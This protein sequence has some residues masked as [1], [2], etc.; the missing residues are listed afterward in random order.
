MSELRIKCDLG[1]YDI[2][3]VQMQ[4]DFCVDL[5]RSNIALFG[6]SMSGKTNFIKLLIN[7]LHKKQNESTEQVFIL[8]FSG[9]LQEYRDMPL[10]SAYFDNSNEEYVKRVFKILENILKSNTKA[11]GS[12]SFSSGAAGIPHTT[13]II[14]NLNA[15]VDETRYTA[16]HEK[17]GRLCRDGRSRGI[18]I[19]FTASDTKG[20]S[21]YLL[22]FE[23][24]IALGLSPEK[25]GEIFG[26][27]VEAVGNI[28]GRGYTNVT[29]RPN[30]ITGTFNM[31]RPY[32]VQCLIAADIRDEECPFMQKLRA[33]FDYDSVD[34]TYRKCV[35][36]YRTFPSELTD[37]D[38][39]QLK[40]PLDADDKIPSSMYVEVGLDYVDFKPVGVDFADSRVIAVYG[41]KEFGKTNL[42]NVLLDG[43][44]KK[45]PGA[46]YVFFDDGR[47]QL[48][49]V[50]EKYSAVLDCEII[51]E[52][53]F[54]TLNLAGGRTVERKLSPMQQFYHLIHEEYLDLTKD[55]DNFVL[56]QI[57]GVDDENVMIDDMPRG[58]EQTGARPTVFVIQSKSV[59]LNSKISS[60]F[61]HYILPELLDVAEENDYIFIFSD[62]KKINDT[63]VNSVFNSTLK[64]VFLLDNIAEFASERGSKSVFGDMDVKSLKEDYARCELGDGYY[65]DVEG[66]SLRKTKFIKVI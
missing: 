64:T 53:G 40:Q 13:F 37:E 39:S 55:Y 47:R 14:D 58:A 54:K 17:F 50:Y 23:Q 7:C 48:K 22:S 35:K 4:P 42:L 29:E 49:E 43:L 45:K 38:Y 25:C 20:I 62:V 46:R 11:L 15:F 33:K 8:D 59:Y 61:L 52:F 6:A 18:T 10:V 44:V 28:P 36:K 3:I 51:N 21:R 27:K 32:E 41:K 5:I 63:E 19:V 57:Y 9:A 2:P 34:G 24:Q 16:Y 30:G 12:S 65:Y 60:D 66:D 1:Q 26:E 56:E 31:N